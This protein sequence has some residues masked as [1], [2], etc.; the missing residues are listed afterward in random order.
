MEVPKCN[1]YVGMEYT[2]PEVLMPSNVPK[3]NKG[4]EYA[5]DLR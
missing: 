2:N 5:Q 4:I 1:M 3:S